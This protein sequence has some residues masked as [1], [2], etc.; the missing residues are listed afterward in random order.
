MF[1]MELS[2]REWDGQIVALGGE[3][4]LVDAVAAFP[5]GRTHARR[6]VVPL[7]RPRRTRWP[8]TIVQSGTPSSGAE[9]GSPRQQTGEAGPSPPPQSHR[10]ADDRQGWPGFAV[11]CTRLGETRSG[12]G[13]PLP[14]MRG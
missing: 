11:S 4:D 7:R 8:H 5:R 12:H 1:S 14:R 3:L 9:H 13:G 2:T 6:V 10:R